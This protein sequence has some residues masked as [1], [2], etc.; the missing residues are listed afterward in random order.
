MTTN[1]LRTLSTASL[2]AFAFASTAAWADKPLPLDNVS[3]WLGGYYANTEVDLDAKTRAGDLSTGRLELDEG[4][5]TVG[6]ARVDFLLFNT[7]G[8]EFD[9]YTLDHS[10]THTLS[11]PFSYQGIPFQLNSTVK[12]KLDFTAGS[13]SWHWWLDAGEDVFGV[14]LGATYYKAKLAVAGTVELNGQ[15]TAAT[16]SWDEDAVAPLLTIAYKHA[17]SDDLRVYVDG[18]GVYKSNGNLHG[19]IYDARGGIE[20]FPWHNVGVGA[21][22]GVSRIKLDREGNAYDANLDIKLDG[23]SLFARF[24]F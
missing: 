19:H 16:A 17:F 12:G 22:Y 13:A 3:V 9:Y 23:P 20:W 5:E 15:T 21:E 7:Q 1:T 8:I 10:A 14:G 4:H 18:S 2:A 11:Q 6:R 24:R